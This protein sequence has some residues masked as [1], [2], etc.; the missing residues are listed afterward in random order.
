MISFLV[1]PRPA[2]PLR[3]A[4]AAALAVFTFVLAGALGGCGGGGEGPG[5]AAA[6]MSEGELA[7]YRQEIAEWHAERV[8]RL[9]QPG[10][11]LTLV[12]LHWFEEG[13][14]SLGSDPMSDV[15]L[16]AKAPARV[17]RVILS[18]D[19][20]LELR[21]NPGVEATVD[22]ERVRRTELITDAE[23]GTT[24]VEMGSLEFYAIQRGDWV[25]LRVRDRE[26]PALAKFAGVD[27]FPVDP[28]WRVEAR[29]E[30]FDPPRE[31]LIPDVTGNDQPMEAPGRL[32]FEVDG[33]EM[34]LQALDGGEDSFFL[35]FADETSG[36][37]TYGA[38]RYLY[39]PR[40]GE[41]G[42]TVIDFNRA[43]N[44]PCA[45]TP[46][47]TCPLPPK[48]NRLPAAIEAGEKV[49]RGEGAH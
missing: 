13:D 36:R 10:G 5:E 19:G 2:P 11:W 6:A 41:D 45:F 34:S 14:N 43:Y 3:G 22:G 1:H 12:G 24:V 29:F 26:S 31:L 18:P 47:A 17:G 42:T 25:G 21:V 39:V 37:E 8:E 32:V 15:V 40:P 33:E 44:P 20:E 48:G 28:D 38:G 23:D 16:P 49:Y 27:T 4:L 30:P 9:S 46:Y 35:I 7:T